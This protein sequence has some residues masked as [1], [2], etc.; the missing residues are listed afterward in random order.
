MID[1]GCVTEWAVGGEWAVGHGV[2]HGP[3]GTECGTGVS[4]MRMLRFK[5]KTT[6]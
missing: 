3:W 1:S 2:R 4:K 6:T 5:N